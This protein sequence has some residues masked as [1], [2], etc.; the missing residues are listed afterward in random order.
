MA[1]IVEILDF[2]NVVKRKTRCPHCKG[3]VTFT[4]R[5]FFNF[6]KTCPHCKEK[7]ALELDTSVDIPCE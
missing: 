6:T 3:V 2:T 7:I 4:M 1:T 5:E